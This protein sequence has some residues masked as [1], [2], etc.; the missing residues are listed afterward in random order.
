MMAEKRVCPDCGGKLRYDPSTGEVMCT[1]CG[2]ILEKDVFDYGQEW[3]EFNWDQAM[4]RRRSGTPTSFTKSDKGMTTEIG[5]SS[6]IYSLSSDQRKQYFIMRKWQRRISTPIERNIKFALTELRRV[7]AQLNLPQI[8]SEE[9]A[10]IYRIAAENGL[11]RGRS[12]ESVVAGSSY[13]ACKKYKIP[14]TLREIA[15][16]FPLD[17]KEV[18]KTYRFICRQLGIKILPPDPLDYV[19]RFANEL[20]L[21]AKV[22]TRAIKIIEGAQAKEITSGKGPTGIAA[23]ALYIA[24]LIEDEKRTQREVADIAGVTE[25][26]IRNRYK[27]LLK[28][29]DLE[30][31]LEKMGVEINSEAKEK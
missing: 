31:K 18:G 17:V 4:S 9:A 13:I 19:Y 14:R 26:T 27:E 10:R 12:M 20:E 5:K 7:S 11:V 15:D 29:L 30:E 23:A 2:V 28:K 3:R 8:I 24:S 1:K 16:V 6:D 22:Q 25:V 21:P